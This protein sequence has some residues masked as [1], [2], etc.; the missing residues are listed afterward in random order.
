MKT[1]PKTGR[2]YKKTKSVI[3]LIYE[4]SSV[5]FVLMSFD[6]LFKAKTWRVIKPWQI[7]TLVERLPRML[8]TLK[9][10]KRYGL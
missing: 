4:I 10:H 9:R 6:N 5:L 7:S 8:K 1:P 2:Y 3:H